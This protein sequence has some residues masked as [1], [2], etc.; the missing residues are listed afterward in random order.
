MATSGSLNFVSASDIGITKYSTTSDRFNFAPTQKWGNENPNSKGGFIPVDFAGLNTIIYEPITSSVNHLGYPVLT[1][2][3]KGHGRQSVT[4][5]SINSQVNGCNPEEKRMAYLNGYVVRRAYYGAG[6]AHSVYGN[7]PVN[8]PGAAAGLNSL[9]L[10]RNGPYG[11]TTWKQIRT[12]NHPVARYQR[13]HNTMSI[14]SELPTP[15]AKMLYQREQND[16]REDIL[17]PHRAQPGS[18][19]PQHKKYSTKEGS[20]PSF[21]GKDEFYEPVITSKHKPFIYDVMI[22]SPDLQTI[23]FA[24]ARQT[25]FNNTTYFSNRDLNAKLKLPAPSGNQAPDWQMTPQYD[26]TYTAFYTAKKLNGR[27]FTT[28]ETIYPKEVNAYRNYKLTKPNY[29]E[30]MGYSSNGFDRSPR[31]IRSFW[32][33]RQDVYNGTSS[34]APTFGRARSLGRPEPFGE[35]PA[36]NSQGVKQDFNYEPDLAAQ[37]ALVE[38]GYVNVYKYVHSSGTTSAS[39]PAG[40]RTQFPGVGFSGAY[41]IWSNLMLTKSDGIHLDSTTDHVSHTTGAYVS[42]EA[43]QPY[44]LYHMSIWPLDVRSDLYYDGGK[45][46]YLTASFGGKGLIIGATP[47]SRINGG[48]R[49]ELHPTEFTSN[50]EAAASCDFSALG[51]DYFIRHPEAVIYCLESQDIAGLYPTRSVGELVYSTKPTIFF[52]RISGSGADDGN[53]RWTGHEG[54]PAAT[55]S[56]QFL[57]H[58]YPYNSPFWCTNLVSGRDPMYDSYD[59]FIG[60]ELKYFG[61]DYSIIPEFTISDKLDFYD[62]WLSEYGGADLT[63]ED[64]FEGGPSGLADVYST[65]TPSL[66]NMSVLPTLHAGKDKIIVRTS[67]TEHANAAEIASKH[68]WN[69]LTLHG[70]HITSSALR[71]SALPTNQPITDKSTKYKYDPN[72]QTRAETLPLGNWNHSWNLDSNSVAFYGSYSHTDDIKNFTTLYSTEAGKGFANSQVPSTITFGCE[73]VKKFLPK[74]GFYPVTRTVQLASYF[75]EAVNEFLNHKN[76]GATN[77]HPNYTLVTRVDNIEKTSLGL[78]PHGQP[79][80]S[81]KQARLQSMLEPFYAPGILYNSI[82]SGIAVDYPIYTSQPLLYTK[83]FSQEYGTTWSNN[84]QNIGTGSFGHGGFHALGTM[85]G[86]PS[87]LMSLPSYRMPFEAIYDFSKIMLGLN[88]NTKSTLTNYLVPDYVDM[89]RSF[90]G[91]YAVGQAFAKKTLPGQLDYAPNVYIGA[92]GINRAVDIETVAKRNYDRTINNFLAETMEFFLQS[93]ED[94]GE[95]K[96]PIVFSQPVEFFS[97]VEENTSYYMNINL[98]MGKDQVMCEG[99]RRSGFAHNPEIPY[100]LTSSLRGYLYGPPIEIIPSSSW[101]GKTA[102][103]AGHAARTWLGNRHEPGTTR[104]IAT[105][106]IESTFA[107][108]TGH[109]IIIPALKSDGTTQNVTLTEHASTTTDSDTNSPT[110]ESAT[111]ASGDLPSRI[112]SALD[113][114]SLLT[115]KDN[116]DNTVTVSQV[117]AGVEGETT[118]TYT[119][120]S[121]GAADISIE[122]FSTE[123]IPSNWSIGGIDGDGYWLGMREG[124]PVAADTPG[125]A[126]HLAGNYHS[127][128]AANLTDPAYQA[129][130][131]PY[132]YGKSTVTLKFIS[133]DEQDDAKPP[134]EY[135]LDDVWTSVVDNSYYF[136]QYDITGGLSPKIPNTASISQGSYTRMKL[137]SSVDIFNDLITINIGQNIQKKLW[138]M[139]PKWM[140]PVLD[141]SSSYTAVNT[142]DLDNP[143]GENGAPNKVYTHVSNSYHDDTTGKSIWGGYGTNPYDKDAIDYITQ[144]SSATRGVSDAGLLQARSRKGIKLRIEGTP[145]TQDENKAGI[146][147]TYQSGI[148]N[149]DGYYINI[150]STTDSTAETRGDLSNLMQIPH[151]AYDIGKVAKNKTVAEAIAIIPYLDSSLMVQSENQNIND[152]GANEFDIKEENLTL[153]GGDRVFKTVEL[154]PGKHF[155]GI[156]KYVFESILSI[157][158]TEKRFKDRTSV[159]NKLKQSWRPNTLETA[160]NTDVGKMIESLLGEG[161]KSRGW[162]L[163]PEF[164]FIH[165]AALPAFQ[166]FI[167]PFNH[168]FDNQ[169]LIDMYQGVMPLSSLRAEKVFRSITAH[170]G[171]EHATIADPNIIPAHYGR[172]EAASTVTNLTESNIQ[173]ILTQANNDGIESITQFAKV[174]KEYNLANFLSPLPLMKEI[175]DLFLG[176]DPTNK[177]MVVVEG[178]N[179]RI[180]M[181]PREFYSKLKFM[182]FKVKQRGITNYSRYKKNQLVDTIKRNIIDHINTEEEVTIENHKFKSYKAN[183]VYGANWPYD[184]F[185][186]IESAK[187]DVKVKVE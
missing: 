85:R 68:R 89:D 116:G 88:P 76:M 111:Y 186:L 183:E 19:L 77:T 128:L 107:V 157:L 79:V 57:R 120:A 5:E 26:P 101:N 134:D 84:H 131:P 100:S 187:I 119:G 156:H 172:G 115:A 59:D 147:A 162:S 7:P 46:F 12:A 43:Y 124:S 117:N 144:L 118:I 32:K 47:H 98:E 91:S 17:A 87:Y 140:C 163:P 10:H 16:Y 169:D 52:Y 114:N 67:K 66:E 20:P 55:A 28:W 152:T 81:I 121:A 125:A 48:S 103:I 75:K 167:V 42:K 22:E 3:L 35:T 72:T 165:N 4:N 104:A 29:E 2:F 95:T 112:A 18:D 113:A 161:Q 148:D 60:D 97:N 14:N 129:W 83:P 94:L 143:Y 110:F 39:F 151:V 58:T 24:V 185:S 133:K 146:A 69:F 139:M 105:L 56:A 170:P 136:E 78:G 44:S 13:L 137:D 80:E 33:K 155:L 154:I 23:N 153:T 38:G 99:P 168:L 40:S 65:L 164:D 149:P 49:E 160:K 82:K 86:G 178:G 180:G 63:T 1:N 138:Y 102:Q 181:P 37:Q 93:Y 132:F 64:S 34:V 61:R 177:N 145:F 30:T 50:Y 123:T 166:M 73:V 130:T 90:S 62:S 36:L 135:T 31:E 122:Q 41:N 96:F 53:G 74:N 179:A 158:L 173:S 11:Y 141:F 108:D 15:S 106:T 171:V 127:G 174:M 9:L 159:Y 45:P 8:N 6:R 126:P 176:Q 70:A 51:P 150:S 175:Q 25:L 71:T 109:G 184:Y 21:Y 54:Y 182:V 142:L 27:N 92:Q